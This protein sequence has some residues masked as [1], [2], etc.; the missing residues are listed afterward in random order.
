MIIDTS[1]KHRFN[2]SSKDLTQD[3]ICL[4]PR[5]FHIV[6]EKGLLDNAIFQL[7]ETLMGFNKNVTKAMLQ[8]EIL[9]LTKN[10]DVIRKGHLEDFAVLIPDDEN[11]DEDNNEFEEAKMVMWKV[12]VCGPS[13]MRKKLF[14][15]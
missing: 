10:W 13:G 15:P 6:S 14:L 12:G 3:L 7:T 2:K 4:D 11:S 8:S 5:S 1:Y 9:D